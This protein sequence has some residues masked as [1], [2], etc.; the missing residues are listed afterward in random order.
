MTEYRRDFI[1]RLA[2]RFATKF[3]VM[4]YLSSH[5]IRYQLFLAQRIS[6]KIIYPI[7]P[8]LHELLFVKLRW[9]LIKQ[10][11][12]R[13]CFLY[14]SVPETEA[15][16]R[17][18]NPKVSV[19]VSTQDNADV[20]RQCLDSIY[21]QRYPNLEVI[22][23][24]DA[25]TDEGKEILE[26]Y[27]QRHPELTR[28]V[29]SEQRSGI[30]NQ[31]QHGFEMANGEL[32]WVANGDSYC[33]ENLLTHLVKYFVNNAVMLAYCRSVAVSGESV[34]SIRTSSEEYLAELDPDLFRSPFVVSAH[35]LVNSAW[36][37]TNILPS[38]SSAVFRHPGKLELLN[39]ENW[40]RMTIYGD[41]IFYLHL[42]RGG[43]VAYT[44]YAT[45][46]YR[47][48]QISAS[49]STHG[50]DAYYQEH[51][52]V[53]KELVNL[54][55]IEESVLERRQQSLESQRHSFHTG[56]SE[57]SSNKCLDHEQVRYLS[58]KRK[59]N[60]LMVSSALS[61]GGGETFP[62]K[63][64][65]MLKLAGYGVT[66]LNCRKVPTEPGVRQMLRGDIPLLELD[67]FDK[68]NTIVDELGIELVHSHHGWV[69]ICISNLLENN[70][71]IQLIVTTH[72][73]YET[74]PP[75][76]FALISPLLKKRVDKFV[77]I[78]DKNLEPFI[79]NSFDMNRF[80]KIGN[81]SDIAP[82]FPVPRA[83]IG[84]PEDAFL[85]CLVSRAIPEKGWHE[86]IEAVKLARKICQKEIHL[87]LIGS[88]PEYERLKPIIT[89]E[90]IHLLGFRANTPDYF[91]TS[92]LG[93]LPSRYPGESVPL[94]LI[95]CFNSN[96]PV[97]TSNIG[98][99][100]KMIL[101]GDGPAG[102]LF[103]LENGNIPI[104]SLAKK[105][106]AYVEDKNLYLDHLNRV[107][108]AAAKFDP[109]V[110]L[111]SYEAVYQELYNKLYI[112]VGNCAIEN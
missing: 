27:Q 37:I 15:I 23:L 19:I 106:V 109:A 59:P 107:P 43:L 44:P 75:A 98:E 13:I 4:R 76:Q 62:I 99:I 20:L 105:I 21:G 39:N 42:V 41:W 47:P 52:Q 69:D 61:V 8:K 51:E 71:H 46:Y 65:N 33:A 53:T 60:I 30:L 40:K 66:F 1:S 56:Y 32:I 34:E 57:D 54:Y 77:Y 14:K 89:D 45:I 12:Y 58:V 70:P 84:V 111:K 90:Y 88:G 3:F 22:L 2:S 87:L 100:G 102:T 74:I 18:F 7:A 78:A 36:A 48:S 10:Y 25:S 73:L 28:Y 67:P 38:I 80:V 95:D 108:A 11:I 68:L 110:L 81:A 9:F 83:E 85:I 64:A 86:A 96:R 55:R 92:D 49:Q 103:D 94:V 72:G 31:W 112:N 79:S 91:A 29:F 6:T 50:K 35:N 82:L 63:L 26:E 17:E 93:M 104:D 24:D 16:P 97:L 5:R 101:T